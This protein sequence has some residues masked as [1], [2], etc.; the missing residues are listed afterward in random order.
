MMS[1]LYVLQLVTSHISGQSNV[2]SQKIKPVYSL[3]HCQDT[4]CLAE[5]RNFLKNYINM[6]PFVHTNIHTTTCFPTQTTFPL[7]RAL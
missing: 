4:V 1:A 3:I 2:N 5:N 6:L 7:H